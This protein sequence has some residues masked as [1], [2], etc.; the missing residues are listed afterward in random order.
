[1]KQ[2]LAH[3]KAWIIALVLLFVIE[4]LYYSRVQPP[5]LTWNSFLDLNFAEDETVQRLMAHHKI[6]NLAEQNADILHVG[7][8]SGLHGVMPKVVMSQIPGYKYINLGVA[9]NVGY[10]GYLN[11]AKIALRENPNA[12][13]L[14]LY[15]SMIGAV[16]RKLLWHDTNVLM[17]EGI[18]RE[19]LRP[20]RHAIQFPTLDVR[21]DILGR[22]YY[23]DYWMKSKNI[24]YTSNRGYQVFNSIYQ[25]SLGWTRETDVEGDVPNDI[26]RFLRKTD[27]APIDEPPAVR[28]LR[29][30]PRVTDEQFFDWWTLSEKSYFDVAYDAFAS[31]AREHNV[32]LILIFNPMPEGIRDPMFE[33]LMDWNAIRNGLD[34]V[35]RRHPEVTVTP[36]DFWPGERFSVFSHVATPYAV[37]SSQ[38]VANLIKPLLSP[39]ATSEKDVISTGNSLHTSSFK[40]DFSKPYAGYG[41]VDINQQTLAFPL[42]YMN[43]TEAFIFADVAPIVHPMEIKVAFDKEMEL[44]D[45]QQLALECNES[46]LSVLKQDSLTRTITWE[47]PGTVSDKYLGWKVLKF[48]RRNSS[49]LIGFSEI[50]IQ[51]QQ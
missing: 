44:D 14:I 5:R 18:Y 13:Y 40:L 37:L 17:S 15:T 6:C 21:P 36:F 2:I 24:L 32:K 26:F 47:L 41:F 25:A 16:P 48:S 34:R 51:P 38:R 4:M 28:A 50:Q 27:K 11:I 49:K 46:K 23:I 9:T 8:S 30:A 3:F 19:F 1:V 7:D 10:P 22:T 39:K 31:L 42:R 43:G 45:L 29:D 33:P 35:K 20:L 12:S